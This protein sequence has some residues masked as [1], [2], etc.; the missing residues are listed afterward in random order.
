MNPQWRFLPNQMTFE[1]KTPAIL[2]GE[3]R[4]DEQRVDSQV[5]E[6]M[7]WE[8]MDPRRCVVLVPVSQYVEPWCEEGLREL[9]RRGYEVRR[10]R[11]FS[12]IDVG[13]SQ[14]ATDALAAGYEELMWI[15]SDIAFSADDV[16]KLRRH[17]LPLVGGIYAKKLR[18]E[19]ACAFLPEMKEL[20]FGREG[21]LLEVLYAGFG[22]MHTRRELYEKM[23]EGLQLPICNERFG[24]KM[25]P[26]FAPLILEDEK[27]KWYLAEDY[28]FCE[29]CRG[30]E[31]RIM[32]D[33]SIR[34]WHI[35]SYGFGWEDAGTEKERYLNYGF[36][37]RETEGNK[38]I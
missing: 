28:A 8:E 38:L 36:A 2:V 14:M 22:F 12:A 1:K 3:D 6:G 24:A 33:G 34:L 9:E 31:V 32:V 35:G 25:I 21:G 7:P 37:I 10:V 26:Y 20:I 11:G 4:E 18:Q 13:R 16:E 27:G 29:R 17:R 19:F 23:Q 15:D 30:N 5:S